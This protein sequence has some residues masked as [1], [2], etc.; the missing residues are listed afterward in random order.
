MTDAQS[1]FERRF[2]LSAAGLAGLGVAS[3]A[4]ARSR[5]SAPGKVERAFVRLD[6][7]LVHYRWGGDPKRRRPLPLYMAHAGP[8]SSISFAAWIPDMAKD[9]FVI[10]PDMQGNGD[11]DPPAKSEQ[12]IA[13]YAAAAVRIMDALGIE[14]VDFYGSHTGAHI[15]AELAVNYPKRVRRLVLDGMPLFSEEFKQQLLANYAPNVVPDSFG[16]HLAWAWRFVRDQSQF[17]PY[18][19]QD[20]E[21][22]LAN[23]VGTP[24]GIHRGVVDVLKALETYHIA[25]RAAFSHDA[26]AVLPRIT[27]PTLITAAERDPLSVYLDDAAA[28]VPGAKKL[29]FARSVPFAER[30]A[31]VQQFLA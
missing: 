10:A 1:A 23:D 16:G 12:Q 28:L 4:Y 30:I 31:A 22:R 11:S 6:E 24:R 7:G 8:G 25:Y 5:P 26:R 15:G 18:F 13:D 17:W 2:L 19:M 27:V 14:Q 9:R 29:R 20:A 21:H 3:P